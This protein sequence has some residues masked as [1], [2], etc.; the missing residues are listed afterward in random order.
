MFCVADRLLAERPIIEKW[1]E[2]PWE[3]WFRRWNLTWEDSWLADCRDPTPLERQF[4]EM[5]RVEQKTWRWEISQDFDRSLGLIDSIRTGNLVV[6]AYQSRY[7]HK[8]YETLSVSSALVSPHTAQALLRALQT[9]SNSHRYRIPPE[10]DELEIDVAD[11]KLKGWLRDVHP[12]SD[13]IDESDPLRNQLSSTMTIPGQLFTEWARLHFSTD[14][15][16]SWRKEHPEKLV[17]LFEHW[18]DCPQIDRAYGFKSEGSRL[19]ISI[20]ELLQFLKESRSSLIIACRIDRHSERRD[21]VE[22]VEGIP[23]YAKLYLIHSNGTIETL[24]R[25]SHLGGAAC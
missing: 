4:W 6:D 2:N 18:N 19:W 25:S 1:E 3:H 11:F 17:T 21:D 7:Y 20:D 5:D 8:D 9:T 22:D 13:G 23:G 14:K 16:K 15:K 12:H 24:G 10:G